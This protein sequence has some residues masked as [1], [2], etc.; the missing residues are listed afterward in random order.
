MTSPPDLKQLRVLASP[1]RQAIVD[2]LE[3]I[4]PCTVAELAE[5]LDHPADGLYYHLRLL[6]ACGLVAGETRPGATR[7]Q[8]VFDVAGRPTELRYSAT[9]RAQVAAVV[10]LVGGMLREALR[11]FRRGFRPGAV[12]QGP[13]RTLWAGRR[14][15]WLSAE[16]LEEVNARI[17]QVVGYLSERRGRTPDGRLYAFTFVV[18]PFGRGRQARTD[19]PG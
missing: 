6:K 13:R 19:D 14:T 17:Q 15:A 16:E 7:P 5:V 10:R 18:S 2:A 8:A 9:D 12:L 3:A 4:G 1:M 11:L